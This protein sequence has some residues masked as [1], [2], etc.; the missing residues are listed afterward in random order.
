MSEL[1]EHNQTNQ[2]FAN[3]RH[4]VYRG[5][6]IIDIHAHVTMTSGDEKPA[7][8]AGGA[9]PT[10]SSEAA[11]DMLMAA[12]EFGIGRTYSM[13][14]PQDIEPLRER[15]GPTLGFNGMIS[16]KKI[17]DPDDAAY[18][19]LDEFLEAGIEMVKLWS[20][21]RGRDR[22]LVVDAPW[23]IE[24]VKRARAAG[25]RTVMVHVGDP[26]IWWLH[27][28]KDTAKFGTKA[29]Q[30]PPFRKMLEMFPDLN[31][32]AAHMGGNPEHADELEAML[33]QYPH[34][35]YDTSATKWQVREVSANREAIR[36]LMIRKPDRF[37]FGSDLVT[38]HRLDHCHYD[39][40]YW[41]HRT[42]WE[43][44]WTGRSPIADG[45]YKLATGREDTPELLGLALPADVLRKVYR[46]NALRVLRR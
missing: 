34:L 29:D 39:S 41:C 5:P 24:G 18:R 26:D 16:K 44:N 37:L 22:G 30:Y 6:P 35:N 20:A 1:L 46:E 13:L 32:I 36:S 25:I 31:W 10:G 23:R 4:F 33:D 8:P 12:Q 38:R 3:R 19:T 2:D 42:L 43:S 27:T 15:F 40:R 7:G 45:D 28:Y 11:A 9:G 14:P 21:P 17:D